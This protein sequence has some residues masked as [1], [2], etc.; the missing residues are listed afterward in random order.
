MSS[1][2]DQLMLRLGGAGGQGPV[3]VIAWHDEGEYE[4]TTIVT[5]YPGDEIREI[6]LSKMLRREGYEIV[7]AI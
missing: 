3:E 2:V 6:D 4:M 7:E 5:E 1:D